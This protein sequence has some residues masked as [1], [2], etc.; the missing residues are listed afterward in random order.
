MVVI[1]YQYIVICVYLIPSDLLI[2]Q[3]GPPLGA[4]RAPPSSRR[5]E[6]PSEEEPDLKKPQP[7]A[8]GENECT[9]NNTKQQN[10]KKNIQQLK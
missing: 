8:K 2:K 1:T 3:E 4:T 10:K 7:R 9:T 5:S 6:W